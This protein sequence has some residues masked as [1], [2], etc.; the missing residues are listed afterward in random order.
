MRSG[1]GSKLTL[2]T[3]AAAYLLCTASADLLTAQRLVQETCWQGTETCSSNW[4]Q[5][6]TVTQS[7]QPGHTSSAIKFP[8]YY[9]FRL[10]NSY[11]YSLFYSPCPCI[12]LQYRELQ[13]SSGSYRTP[14][15]LHNKPCSVLPEAGL[16]LFPLLLFGGVGKE[17][18][19]YFHSCFSPVKVGLPMWR[20][21]RGHMQVWGR[22]ITD[23]TQSWISKR[24][25]TRKPHSQSCPHKSCSS[26]NLLANVPQVW[27]QRSTARPNSI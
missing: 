19:N 25:Y 9:F 1:Q 26:S 12:S 5:L 18:V 24:G 22:T 20:R 16:G 10:G 11:I 7:T 2:C 27:Q 15:Q 17:V 23:W 13:V 8:V 3:G 6:T 4:K 14:E 21:M